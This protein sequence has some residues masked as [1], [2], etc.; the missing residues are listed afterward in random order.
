MQNWIQSTSKKSKRNERKKEEDQ[1]FDWEKGNLNMMG[2]ETGKRRW[3][4]GDLL[5]EITGMLNWE[6]INFPL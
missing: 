5:G 6:I 4:V 1:W 3:I 2:S